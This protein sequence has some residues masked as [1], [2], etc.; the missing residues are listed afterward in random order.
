MVGD[1]EAP[2]SSMEWGLPAGYEDGCRGWGDPWT[3]RWLQRQLGDILRGWEGREVSI[4]VIGG[5]LGSV[6][7]VVQFQLALQRLG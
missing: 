1:W 3:L 4:I 2:E 5:V 6:D 7:A